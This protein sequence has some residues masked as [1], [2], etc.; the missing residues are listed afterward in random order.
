MRWSGCWSN[1]PDNQGF[2][3]ADGTGGPSGSDGIAGANKAQTDL[4]AGMKADPVLSN[5][6]V[7]MWQG[8]WLFW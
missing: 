6:P 5:I 4:Y 2:T 8:V 1:E 3:Y 7:D